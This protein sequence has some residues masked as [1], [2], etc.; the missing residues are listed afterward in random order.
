MIPWGNK[1]S[2]IIF[3]DIFIDKQRARGKMVV[4][5][6]KAMNNDNVVISK[7]HLKKAKQ[8]N[9]IRLAK[10]LKLDI[11]GMSQGHIVRLVAWRLS[12][13][14]TRFADPNKRSD[15]EAMWENLK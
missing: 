9:L 4:G 15:Y 14:V 1:K 11:R 7:A 12:R 3:N 6:G 13:P 8:E 2:R 10:A 5:K